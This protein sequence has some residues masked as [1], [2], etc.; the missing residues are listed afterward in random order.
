VGRLKTEVGVRVKR[1]K[2]FVGA[3][4]GV[5]PRLRSEVAAAF[6]KGEADRNAV[7]LTVRQWSSGTTAL[8]EAKEDE[9]DH[10]R[11]LLGGVLAPYWEMQSSKWCKKSGH[12]ICR[13]TPSVPWKSGEVDFARLGA[14]LKER[15]GKL[16][17]TAM[18][19]VGE[20]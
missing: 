2:S 14:E 11:C 18:A 19:K 8:A 17:R 4:G 6:R 12:A 7:D 1:R 15:G 10:G 16:E 20:L 5:A 13:G 3:K 9:K